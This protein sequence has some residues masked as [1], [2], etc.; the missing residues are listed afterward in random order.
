VYVIQLKNA[1]A[2]DLVVLLK[3]VFTRTPGVAVTAD[4]RTNALVV[5]ADR[6]TLETIQALV[7]RLDEPAANPG[8]RTKGGS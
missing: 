4:P 2:V 7:V 1:S 8:P 3:D 6:K 5:N